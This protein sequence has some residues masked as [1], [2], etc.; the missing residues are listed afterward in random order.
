MPNSITFDAKK[1]SSIIDEN[2]SDDEEIGTLMSKQ[3]NENEFI[4]DDM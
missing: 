3:K 1:I 4:I 2:Q